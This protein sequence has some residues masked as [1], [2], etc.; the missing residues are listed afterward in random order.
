MLAARKG[1]SRGGALAARRGGSGGKQLACAFIFGADALLVSG[2]VGRC[3]TGTAAPRLRAPDGETPPGG[4][5]RRPGR[6]TADIPP[7][8]SFPPDAD[9]FVEDGVVAP[10][11]PPHRCA[12][13]ELQ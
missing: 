7:G 13:P 2:C 5:G 4:A 3:P 6:W 1:W 11:G 8:V 12:R 9:I 10:A